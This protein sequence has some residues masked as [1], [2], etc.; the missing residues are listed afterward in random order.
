MI[1]LIE[2]EIVGLTVVLILGVMMLVKNGDG[3]LKKLK[4][5]EVKAIINEYIENHSSLYSSYSQNEH[6]SQTNSYYYI[7]GDIHA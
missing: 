6:R 1:G 4:R 5:V 7:Y 3:I 2:G